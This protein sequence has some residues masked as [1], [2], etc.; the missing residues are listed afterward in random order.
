[1]RIVIVEIKQSP[2]ALPHSPDR[3]VRDLHLCGASPVAM[4]YARVRPRSGFAVSVECGDYGRLTAGKLRLRKSRS[5]RGR[6]RSVEL[7]RP[8]TPS[9]ASNRCGSACSEK[10]ISQISSLWTSKWP[11]GRSPCQL[12]T[13]VDFQRSGAYR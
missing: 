8:I 3:E 4:L 10:A 1:M 12:E 11:S 5:S 7:N 9:C 13:V 6:G 2:A